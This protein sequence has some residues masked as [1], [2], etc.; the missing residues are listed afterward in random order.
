MICNVCDSRDYFVTQYRTGS[1]TSPAAPARQ[2]CSCGAI[3]LRVSA[4]AT[5]GEEHFVRLAMAMRAAIFDSGSF[6]C[7][8]PTTARRQRAS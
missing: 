6:S 8:E 4:A 2:C 1:G 3:R 7:E 5:Q